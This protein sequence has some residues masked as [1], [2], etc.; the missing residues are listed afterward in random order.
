MSKTIN[1]LVDKKLK[2]IFADYPDTEDLQELKEELA[3]DLSA[4]ADDKMATASSEEAAVDSAFH[5]F[6]DIDEVINQVLNESDDQN[7]NNHYH[8]TSHEHHIDLDN[9]G[10]RIDDGKVLNIDS[11]G[12][13]INNGKAVSINSDGVKLGNVF[14]NED[15]INFKD[16]P[17]DSF[18]AFNAN[19]QETN[20]DTEVHVESL[21]LTDESEFST[22][23]ISKIDVAYENASLKILPIKGNKIVV[24]EYMSR[25]NPEYQVKTDI[26][27]DTLVIKQGRIPHFLPLRIKAQVLIPA[28]FVGKLRVNSR[29]GSLL[30]QDLDMLDEALV[31]VHSGS[32]N[33]RNIEIGKLLIRASSGRTVLE[34]VTAKD[35]LAIDSKS[36]TVKMEDV[37]SSNY[38][39]E[40]K[41]GTIKGIGLGGAGQVAAKSG[42]VKLEFSKITADVNITNSSGTIKV[43]MPEKDSFKFDLE[44][45]SGN[46]KVNHAANFEHKTQSFKDGTVGNDPQYKITAKASSGTI[47][48]D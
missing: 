3:A 45:R 23:G 12:I 6:G 44:A 18:D 22:D 25:T 33:L 36:G 29:S 8:K 43:V 10:I 28:Q 5:E 4:S 21:P 34:N 26:V 32:V 7:N 41:S 2:K 14:I 37:F 11:D 35:S 39:I 38:D 19:F 16:K 30:V 46:V 17:K 40:A 20:Y 31:N 48:L 9:D 47:K 15:G 1:K 13:T 24:R 27:D 42:T